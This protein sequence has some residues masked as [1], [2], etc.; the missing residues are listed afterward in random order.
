MSEFPHKFMQTPTVRASWPAPTDPTASKI[1]SFGSLPK[2]WHFG[3]G[4]AIGERVINVALSWVEFLRDRGINDIDVAPSESGAILMACT[5]GRRY[6]EIILEPKGAF[7][8]ARD[9]ENGQAIYERGLSEEQAKNLISQLSRG[10]WSTFAG[11]TPAN[12]SHSTGD[13]T[14]MLFVIP[15]KVPAVPFRL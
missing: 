6:T 5:V 4:K 13:F 11:F 2:G 12:I 8:V 1:R 7:T 15:H 3:D 14:A 9:R 10:T